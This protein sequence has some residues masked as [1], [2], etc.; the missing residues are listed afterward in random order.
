M[1]RRDADEFSYEQAM[2]AASRDAAIGQ[3]RG[4]AEGLAMNSR[5]TA[6]NSLLDFADRTYYR[7][8]A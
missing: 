2:G 6:L 3:A 5:S 7:G 8:K 1:M 4:Q